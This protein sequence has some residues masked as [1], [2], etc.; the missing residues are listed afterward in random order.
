[1]TIT[2]PERET[3]TEKPIEVRI[4]ERAA[5]IIEE[6]GHCS[7]ALVKMGENDVDETVHRVNDPRLSYC[8]LGAIWRAGFE[9][10]VLPPTFMELE[11]IAAL[12]ERYEDEP[13]VVIG[14]AVGID[15]DEGVEQIHMHND[16]HKDA[17][18][19]AAHLRQ[20]ASEWQE[21]S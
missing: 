12:D 8:E 4:L 21:K 18:K 14:S 5:L 11:A 1:M 3:I 6:H 17:H 20:L 10:G 2:L 16:H 15:T 13:Y 19:S 9:F 7:G